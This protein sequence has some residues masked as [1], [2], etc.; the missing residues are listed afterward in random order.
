M[1]NQLSQYMWSWSVQFFYFWK[2]EKKEEKIGWKIER[3]DWAL[4]DIELSWCF[5]DLFDFFDKII[6]WFGS[7]L[8]GPE[9]A[10][11][12]IAKYSWC[13]WSISIAALSNLY[14]N[15]QA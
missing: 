14:G 1:K 10:R 13:L 8:K 9:T 5:T 4:A 2:I 11:L 3:L 6:E 7:F 15:L 12:A